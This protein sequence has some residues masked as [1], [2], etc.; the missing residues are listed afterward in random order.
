MEALPRQSVGTPNALEGAPLLVCSPSA[1]YI[2]GSTLTVDDGQA[3]GGD[4]TDM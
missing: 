1:E 2:T 4:L 3:F